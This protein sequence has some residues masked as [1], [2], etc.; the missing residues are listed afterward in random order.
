MSRRRGNVETFWNLGQSPPTS[1]GGRSVRSYI[2]SQS[3]LHQNESNNRGTCSTRGAKSGGKPSVGRM[4]FDLV[5]FFQAVPSLDLSEKKMKEMARSTFTKVFEHLVSLVI[6]EPYTMGPLESDVPRMLKLLGYPLLPKKSTLQ[7][8]GAPNSL[9][10][11]VQMLY[12]LMS[13]AKFQENVCSAESF[14]CIEKSS[15]LDSEAALFSQ[16]LAGDD[17]VLY[18]PVD[19][20][21][22]NELREQVKRAEN[23]IEM[24][25]RKQTKIEEQIQPLL[26]VEKELDEKLAEKMQLDKVVKNC[27]IHQES[28]KKEIED[29]TMQMRAVEDESEAIQDQLLRLKVTRIQTMETNKQNM[30]KIQQAQLLSKQAESLRQDISNLNNELAKERMKASGICFELEELRK[31]IAS[32]LQELMGLCPEMAPIVKSL[33]RDQPVDEEFL[34]VLH[35][36]LVELKVKS[37]EKLLEMKFDC[38]RKKM[39]NAAIDKDVEELKRAEDQL[40]KELDEMLKSNKV[41]VTEARERI[42]SLRCELKELQEDPTFQCKEDY[43]RLQSELLAKLDEAEMNFYKSI[44]EKN[45]ER[46]SIVYELEMHLQIYESLFNISSCN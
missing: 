13:L 40:E 23:N 10:L 43:E 6:D 38:D 44:L 2:S 1:L 8:L 32:M 37:D 18:T 21:E 17:N 46:L 29:R 41:V 28:C 9:P 19:S 5:Y 34:N 12:W 45:K 26:N 24:L 35:S 27:L 36:T 7:T 31:K 3:T 22:L 30:E 14:Q 39:A 20:A 16:W 42:S 25:R 33:Q 15:N 4:I 11:I